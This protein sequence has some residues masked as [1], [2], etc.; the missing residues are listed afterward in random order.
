MPL[1]PCVWA[2]LCECALGR[3]REKFSRLQISDATIFLTI[4]KVNSEVAL[5]DKVL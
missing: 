5:P 4:Q 2:A 1:I 3:A